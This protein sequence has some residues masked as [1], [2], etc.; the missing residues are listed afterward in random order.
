MEMYLS[1]IDLSPKKLKRDLPQA[2]PHRTMLGMGISVASLRKARGLSQR[3]LARLSS[4][5]RERM[6]RLERDGLEKATYGELLRISTALGMKVWELFEPEDA[7]DK[8]FSL[9]KV[10]QDV[11]QWGPAGGTFQVT[12][13]FGPRKDLFVGKLFLRGGSRLSSDEVPRAEKI[14]L[15]VLLGSLC[16]ERGKETFALREG[17]S[18]L[19][20]DRASYA[21]ENQA[22]REGV[23]FLVTCPSFMG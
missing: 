23:A 10:G 12:S 15:Q 19:L 16:L 4:I 6:R 17:D 14:F 21:L 5:S 8:E 1:K 18:V 2:R 20:N 13:L 7:G 3:R 9:A 22:A 11:L